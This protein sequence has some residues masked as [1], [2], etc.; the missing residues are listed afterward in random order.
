MI[1]ELLKTAQGKVNILFDLW[2]SSNILSLCGL[3][4]YF[5]DIG[6][7]LRHFL[8]SI[9]WLVGSYYGVNILE[10]VA[11]IIYEFDL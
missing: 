9:P 1:I 4:V 7:K 11:A 2:S 10:S 3:V 8:L 6:G 5:I